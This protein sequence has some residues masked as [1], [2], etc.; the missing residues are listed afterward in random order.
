MTVIDLKAYLDFGHFAL[1]SVKG[2][3][4]EQWSN[5]LCSDNGFSAAQRI[6]QMCYS[7][8][9]PLQSP[10]VFV[11]GSI[12]LNGICSVKLPR[13][14]AGHRGMSACSAIQAVSHGHSK[15]HFSLDSRARQRN[16]RLAHLC[17]LCPSLDSY[18][19]P[20]LCKRRVIGR[21]GTDCICPRLDNHRPVPVIVPVGTISATQGRCKNAYIARPARQ[22]SYVY[23]HLGRPFARCQYSRQPGIRTGR[24]VHYGSRLPGFCSSIYLYTKPL[25]LHYT[26]KEQLRLFQSQLQSCRQKHWTSLRS[27]DTA[28]W[29]SHVA[30]LSC[31]SSSHQ[32]C[33]FRYKQKTRL[34][35]KQLCITGTDH[36]K[37]LQ[38]PLADRTLLQMDQAVSSHQNVFGN[39][40][41]RRQ[42]PNMDCNQRVRA[43]CHCQERTQTRTKSWRNHANSQHC[44]F[45]ASTDRTS[46]YEL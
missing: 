10:T 30:G 33:R 25:S 21:T 8:Q 29:L 11:H 7:I 3:A 38:M 1:H 24:T 39:K 32:L 12:P 20:T 41:Q 23:T 13:K 2:M 31:C 9:R 17:R 44:T 46:T 14:S 35:N 42:D 18:R 27:D 40:L 26:A 15:S 5:S 43:C 45:R 4:D 28:K 34:L 22:H 36:C 37:T 19:S 16:T 6:P